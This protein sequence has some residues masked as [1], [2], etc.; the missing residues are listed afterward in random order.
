MNETYIVDGQTYIVRPERKQTFLAKFPNAEL[1]SSEEAGKTNDSQ[2]TGVT[3]DQEINAAPEVVQPDMALPLEPTFL[4]LQKPG[5]EVSTEEDAPGYVE[6]K[7]KKETT[8]DATLRKM[9]N[10]VWVDNDKDI[11]DYVKKNNPNFLVSELTGISKSKTPQA[12]Q[13]EFERLL[14]IGDP[15]RS[16]PFFRKASEYNT[17]EDLKLPEAREKWTSLNSLKEYNLALQNNDKQQ[18]LSNINKIGKSYLTKGERYIKDMQDMLNDPKWLSENSEKEINFQKNLLK[19]AREK[20]NAGDLLY[21]FENGG[22]TTLEKSNL[23]NTKLNEKI[24]KTAVELAESSDLEFLEEIRQKEYFELLTLAKQAAIMQNSIGRE[25]SM[26]EGV[27]QGA[28]ALKGTKTNWWSDKDNLNKIIE[29]GDLSAGISRLPGNSAIA[30]SFNE[31]LNAFVSINKAIQIN[32][33]L[34]TT[35]KPNYFVEAVSDIQKAI[36]GEGN[37]DFKSGTSVNTDTYVDAFAQLLQDNNINGK[38]A[39]KDKNIE[40]R[41]RVTAAETGRDVATSM[42]GLIATVVAT[43]K[44]PGFKSMN[45]VINSFGQAIKFGNK[46]KAVNYA[47]NGLIGGTGSSYKG[48]KYL[49]TN[50]SAAKEIFTLSIA[51][52]I[53]AITMNAHAVDPIFAGSLGAAN[54]VTEAAVKYT[55]S[56][57]LKFISPLLNIVGKSQTANAVGRNIF[58]S[59]TGTGA[60]ITAELAQIHGNSL[61]QDGKLAEYEEYKHIS[62]YEHLVGNYI[63]LSMVGAASGGFARA[64]EKDILAY[65]GNTLEAKKA[66]DALGITI[67]KD[68]FYDRTEIKEKHKKLSNN[69]LNDKNLSAEQYSKKRQALNENLNQLEHFN[70]VKIA[71]N[72]AK[73]NKE[74]NIKNDSEATIVANKI[75]MQQEMNAKDVQTLSELDPYLILDKLG[76][77]DSKTRKN[78]LNLINQRK[79]ESKTIIDLVDGRKFQ[80]GSKERNEMIQGLLELKDLQ[81]QQKILESTSKNNSLLI[82]DL[83]KVKRKVKEQNEKLEKLDSN[84]AKTLN[85]LREKDIAFAKEAASKLNINV[86]DSA[87][88]KDSFQEQY[89]KSEAGKEY[90]K[91]NN[92]FENVKESNGYWDRKSNTVF[93]NRQRAKE[94]RDVSVGSH[95][96]FHGI[97]KNSFRDAKGNVTSQGIKLIDAFKQTL[98]PKQIEV[99]EKRIKENYEVADKSKYY[100]EYL[101]AFSDAIRSKEVKLDNKFTQV[102]SA[103]INILKGKGFEKIGDT[104]GESIYNLLKEYNKSIEKGKLSSKIIEFAEGKEI[105]TQ[106]GVA[107]QAAS[108]SLDVVKKLEIDLRNIKEK[109]SSKNIEFENSIKRLEDAGKFE[110][111][112]R[113]KDARGNIGEREGALINKIA[114]QYKSNIE[115]I[116]L[117]LDNKSKVLSTPTYENMSR[118]EAL[119]SIYN[120]TKP[121]LI[122]HIK[123]FKPSKNNN[124][125]GWIMSQL[126]NKIGTATGVK[127]FRKTEFTSTIDKTTEKIINV[128]ASKK[129][130]VEVTVSKIKR[131]LDLTNTQIDQ[132]KINVGKAVEN[133]F[134][135]GITPSSVAKGKPQQFKTS[136]LNEIS[137]E[138]FKLVKQKLNEGK[139][140]YRKYITS[141]EGFDLVKSVDLQTMTNSLKGGKGGVFKAF[142]EPVLDANGKQLTMSKK[143]ANLK[144]IPYDKAGSGPLVYKKKNINYENFK[145]QWFDIV[146]NKGGRIDGIKDAIAKAVGKRLKDAVPSILKNPFIEIKPGQTIDLL[147]NLNSQQ[148]QKFLAENQINIIAEKLSVS[149][150]L[151]FSINKK[152]VSF[153]KSLIKLNE[154]QEIINLVKNS[155]KD[156]ISALDKATPIG[157]LLKTLE[158]NNKDLKQADFRR[159]KD[160]VEEIAKEENIGLEEA[161][162]RENLNETNYNTLSP[163]IG[164]KLNFKDKNDKVIELEKPLTGSGFGSKK[165]YKRDLN[166]LKE[167][168]KDFPPFETLSLQLQNALLATVGV[169]KRI[170]VYNTKTK[171]QERLSAAGTTKERAAALVEIFGKD[172]LKGRGNIKDYPQGVYQP[173]STGKK[174]TPGWGLQFKNKVTKILENTKTSSIEKANAIKELLTPEGVTFEEFSKTMENNRAIISKS[175]ENLYDRFQKK[176]TKETIEDIINI[177]KIQTNHATGIFKG[178]VPMESFTLKPGGP[179]TKK[180]HNEHMI[181][182][183]NSNKRFLNILTKY[184][185]KPIKAKE[186]IKELVK[187]LEQGLISEN[188]R[189]TKDSKEMGGASGQVSTDVIINTFIKKGSAKDQIS[190]KSD[191]AIS[192]AE[193]FY[194]NYSV[195]VLKN[196]LNKVGVNEMSSTAVKV[197]Q[198]IE[199]TVNQKKLEIK[200][201]KIATNAGVASS[202]TK[203]KTNTEV[204]KEIENVDKVN[205]EKQKAIYDSK[206]LNKDF[207]NI[208]QDRTGVEAFKT[209]ST[210]KASIQGKKKGNWDFYVRPAAEDFTGLIYKT[211]PKGKKGNA[212]MKWYQENLIDPFTRGDKATA[213]E[214]MSVL[215]DY[216]AVVKQIKDIPKTLKKEAA[217]GFTNEQAVRVYNWAK[218]GVKIPGISAKDAIKLTKA[219]ENNAELK[220]FAEQIVELNKGDGYPKPGEN[221]LTGTITTDLMAGIGKVKRKKHM[222]QFINNVDAIYTQENLNKLESQFGRSYRDALE[223]MLYRMKTGSNR[224]KSLGKI[225]SAALEWI[226][227]SV[228]V[229]MFF[230]TR[231]ASLQLLSIP[232]Y[233][234][235][236][237]NNPFKAGAKFANQPQFWGDFITL[238]NSN[239]AVSRRNGIKLNVTESEI[240]EAAA[241]SGNKAQGAINYMLEKGFIF[242]KYADGFATAFGGSTMYRN[243]IETYKKEGFS[244][245]EA[246]EKAM[247]DWEE[248][249]E[250]TQQSGRT[251]KISQEQ[252]S[253]GGRLVLAFGNTGMQYTRI[254]KRAVQ[255]LV[256][257]RISPGYKTQFES[258]ASNVSKA[259]YYST[260]ASSIFVGLQNALFEA[261]FNPDADIDDKKIRAAENM[262]DNA[263][264]GTGM[265]GA[266]LSTMRSVA[267]KLYKESQDK[268]PDYEDAAWETLN[269]SPPIDIKVTKFRSA[270]R[271]IKKDMDDIKEKGALNPTNPAYLASAQVISGITNLPLD[272]LFRKVNNLNSALQKNRDT[273]QRIA[274]IGGYSDYELGIEKN[275]KSKKSLKPRKF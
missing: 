229:T 7:V 93:I 245:K 66:A 26:I 166:N 123:G 171:K 237:D 23:E 49:P 61:I 218:Q 48:L 244:E 161:I 71:K 225:E 156:L 231:S 232:N 153:Q 208:I 116:V 221:W 127:G 164:K 205:L 2:Q 76:I 11:E 115:S 53:G 274:L 59:T 184:K 100:E 106:E 83:N 239:W 180:L 130:Q 213:N 169:G 240:A 135:K 42:V 91:K 51:D 95:E 43:K 118:Q 196:I 146:L 55:L 223:N 87:L 33:D 147:P 219:V 63:G 81:N 32:S 21:D 263:L 60:M 241:R 191:K 202:K 107:K 3:V 15:N 203:N 103:V 121:Y 251:D 45:N 228:G 82:F 141:K 198:I 234:N 39:V 158:K 210:A 258:D 222:E 29:N 235:L 92:K 204:L 181:E 18:V 165:T 157:S 114:E 122:Q 73:S 170:K 183:F 4:G 88:T 67:K 109:E 226:N 264:R 215:N 266:A 142:I 192:V 211:L 5:Q 28:G 177:L 98:T 238:M 69:L 111:A 145:D 155:P 243:R 268:R 108:R 269:V 19:E 247:K 139:G 13:D 227:G 85:E 77:K 209:F 199:N 31:K 25:M 37:V 154:Y 275:K 194:K 101:T 148:R 252:A 129:E 176:P 236:T 206:D 52:Q 182:L 167:F 249:S 253:L 57:R 212:A 9:G 35:K 150:G 78:Y 30:N 133:V 84:Y 250:T 190:L 58:T 44:L 256:N 97:I 50:A 64:L 265:Y 163:E 41:I 273:W 224:P 246:K 262:V 56:N 270:F 80:K 68:G 272:R 254:P 113:M 94:T 120:A 149:P 105:I 99:I 14:N 126:S 259:V 86:N 172:V 54:S 137:N 261:A 34:T 74:N 233:I 186:Q 112:K 248:I 125:D 96:L 143:E 220:A 40:E 175:Y 134:N 168:I 187:E 104:S 195:K 200:N 131:D 193:S 188:T 179:G 8:S 138:S 38:D 214:R 110:A 17:R 1:I 216:N 162:K 132:A 136:I 36:T 197:K 201:K 22:F 16:K 75:K 65:K 124:L 10:N 6:P 79:I 117:K 271:A 173:S 12:I 27:V 217:E 62:T 174:Q 260:I 267:S 255:D 47:V 185:N 257:R 160:I 230:N 102:T 128:E 189:I 242:T 152:V 151:S 140:G 70:N 207:N 24:N 46:S 159:I 89:E 119:N 90:F 178:L 72:T 20:T 144:G